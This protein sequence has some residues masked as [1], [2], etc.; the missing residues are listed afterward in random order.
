MCA[1]RNLNGFHF[2][3]RELKVSFADDDKQ[4]S[5]L[6][7]KDME[8]RDTG[9]VISSRLTENL[10]VIDNLRLKGGKGGQHG[11]SRESLLNT[12]KY[13]PISASDCQRFKLNTV[14]E[15]LDSLT[16]Q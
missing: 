16:E 13:K 9:E 11:P 14:E 1:L 2:G 15:T 5:N 6:K 7:E 12:L 10:S 4:G 3:K 8:G